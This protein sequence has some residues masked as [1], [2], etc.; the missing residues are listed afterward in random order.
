M[1]HFFR[2]VWED[3]K[4]FYSYRILHFILV[5][6]FLFG[7]SMIFFPAFG[8][9]NF[10]YV[11][12][13]ILPVIIFS[14]SL[15][16]EREEKSVSRLVSSS[17]G[18]LKII[19]AKIFAALGLEL[20]PFIGFVIGSL[21]LGHSFSNDIGID[22]VALF[23]AYV[24]G[25]LVHIIVGLSL[26]IIAKSSRI[27]SLSYITYIIVFSIAPILYSNGIIPEGFQYFLIISPAFL[28]GVL[29][30]T[31]ISDALNP[32]IWLLWLSVGLQIVYAGVLVTFVIRPFFKQ[33]VLL[34]DAQ[35]QK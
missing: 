5:L 12:T 35:P 27:L 16:I 7:M 20:I 34:I 15:F 10:L 30:D 23:F 18:T 13:F 31:I 6:T 24:L 32:E 22:Y 28:S 1:K 8:L 4:R 2:L 3:L 19:F 14:I 25:V 9:T 26:S 29:L 17:T 11:A 21:V 33:F